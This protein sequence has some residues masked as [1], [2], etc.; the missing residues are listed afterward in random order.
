MPDRR[1][2][3]FQLLAE[4]P[5]PKATQESWAAYEALGIGQSDT[6]LLIDILSDNALYETIYDAREEIPEAWIPLHCA[7]ALGQLRAVEATAPLLAVLE[8][9]PDDDW[10]AT[11]LASAMALIG[12]GA[13]PMLAAYLADESKDL[14]DRSSTAE[15]IA[16]IGQQHPEAKDGCVHTLQGQLALYAHTDPTLNGLLVSDLLDLKAL[17]AMDTIRLAYQTGHVD[18]S[19]CGDL[20]DVEIAMGLRDQR[21]TPPP[22]LNLFSKLEAEEEFYPAKQNQQPIHRGEKVG[23]NDPCPCGS[24]KK[25]KKCCLN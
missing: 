1:A 19:I 6:P 8:A 25:Y 18:W 11:D 21:S 20:E 5:P 7:R 24:G 17:D 13:L 22:K 9:L 3:L 15:C 2:E 23:R 16:A 12:P 4:I 14:Y 10:F